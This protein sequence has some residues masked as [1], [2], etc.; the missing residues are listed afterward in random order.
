MKSIRKSENLK[1]VN[2]EKL[3]LSKL[4]ITK[5]LKDRLLPVLEQMS[6]RKGGSLTAEE[7]I[8]WLDGMDKQRSLISA[9]LIA[10]EVGRDLLRID[11]SQIISK[12]TGETERNLDVI[13]KEAS[14][15]NSAVYFEEAD[16]LFG[17]RTEVRDA[18]DR[19]ANIEVN[20]FLKRVE[21]FGGVVI[22]TSAR[23]SDIDP[24]FL[25]RLR[26]VVQL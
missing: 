7:N 21:M 2:N 15:T 9:E 24:A 19:Y 16:A 17:K 4:A 12:H 26:F 8:I 6:T 11:L 13:F 22:L 5:S 18:H 3:N 1:K 14:S 23:K 20:A 10:K 25:R